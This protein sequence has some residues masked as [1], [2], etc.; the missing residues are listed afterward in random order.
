[1]KNYVRIFFEKKSIVFRLMY[2]WQQKNLFFFLIKTLSSVYMKFHGFTTWVKWNEEKLKQQKLK[3]HSIV[4]FV[5]S[6]QFIVG[7]SWSIPLWIWDAFN[8]QPSLSDAF[9]GLEKW[10]ERLT[11][12]SRELK[13][14]I[15]RSFL[16]IKLVKRNVQRLYKVKWVENC[17]PF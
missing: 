4:R 12:C 17:N 11:F 3:R 1:M 14:K 7:S 5:V 15:H 6:Q 13:R 16:D 2:F 9:M 8:S 10:R